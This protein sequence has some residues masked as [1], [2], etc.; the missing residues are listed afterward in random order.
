MAKRRKKKKNK[1]KVFLVLLVLVII[2]GLAIVV[3]P[4]LNKVKEAELELD[5]IEI[6]FNKL[7]EDDIDEDINFESITSD[8]FDLNWSS[9]KSNVISNIGKVNRPTF[10]NGNEKVKIT[11][12]CDVISDGLDGIVYNLLGVSG[13]SFTK[14]VKV[15]AL[16]MSDEE[17]VALV[18]DYLDIPENI[19]ASISLPNT[20]NTFENLS[21]SWT[22]SNEEVLLNNGEIKAVG[23]TTLKAKIKVGSVEKEK[24]FTV[25]TND[26]LVID[27]INY[28]FSDY[29]DTSYSETKY[30]NVTLV[31]SLNEDG[32]VKFKVQNGDGSGYIY[33]NNIINSAKKIS[34]NYSYFNGNG[35]YTKSTF[36][37]LLES[38]DNNI[39]TEVKTETL[40]DNEN[41]TF[42][43]DCLGKNAYYKIAIETEYSEKMVVIDNLKA[44]RF[45]CQDDI[46]SSLILPD[47]VNSNVNLP[48]TT[49]YGGM[50]SYE[51]NSSALTSDGIVTLGNE[52]QIVNLKVK[53]TGF[54]FEVNYVHEVKVSGKNQK[55]PIEI[56]FIDVG[57]YGHSDCGES[58][59][60]KYEDI[61]V[62]IDAG[63]RYD[64]T[65]KAIKEVLDVKL[66]DGILEYAIA[67]HPDSDH[68]GSMDNVIN[69]YDVKNIIR[70]N[71]TASSGVYTDF[72]NS[73]N[74]ENADVCYVSDSLN[75]SNGCKK[76]IN[77]AEDIFIEILD[78]TFYNEEENNARS[79]VCVLNAYG[80]R[81]LFT[82]DADN[83]A[84]DL[85]G[86]YM[87]SVGNIDIL[88]LVHHGTR[89]GTTSEFLKAVDPEVCIVT[90][91][92]YFGNKHGHPTYEALS[93][94][95]AYD[96]NIN[97]YAVVGG[98]ADNCEL[99]SSN[100]YHCEPTDYTMDRN[101]M[102]TITIDNNGYIINSEYFDTNK[103]LVEIRDTEFWA[104]RSQIG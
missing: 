95:Y 8:L 53:V 77:I 2:I 29:N 62:L 87:N 83:G 32:T 79:I 99:S 44:E 46:I 74:A 35:S 41:H 101:G 25:T 4:R 69:T 6:A 36:I 52:S 39:W 27:E 54:D 10:S 5:K 94:I 30:K 76:I 43:Y 82:G 40:T 73:V 64:D 61:E 89:E 65:F 16:P 68:I 72:D 7:L 58:I 70:F 37:K 23:T 47:S 102:I 14:E 60:I 86:A 85:E 24:T 49:P 12:D 9:D 3:V 38:N 51:S 28:D 88:K 98:D 1:G 50:I 97:V 78:T 21:I 26:N 55:T 67:T 20:L 22:S 81:T 80:V 17:K 11:L 71:G 59:L 63:D 96:E 104:A 75:N 31:N 84:G 45:L 13:D 33:T 42:E 56:N 48:F 100:S 103:G 34:F 90:N 91:G 57:K 92:N 93:R 18:Y 15:I 66:E 19:Y